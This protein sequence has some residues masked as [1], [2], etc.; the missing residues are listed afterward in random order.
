MSVDHRPFRP[1]FLPR[2]QEECAVITGRTAPPRSTLGVVLLSLSLFPPAVLGVVQTQQGNTIRSIQ[3]SPESNAAARQAIAP[4]FGMPLT[5]TV[6]RAARQRLLASLATPAGEWS[7]DTT[8]NLDING[9]WTI[10]LTPPPVAAMQP[11]REPMRPRSLMPQPPPSADRFPEAIGFSRWQQSASQVLVVR[12]DRRL[13]LKTPDGIRGFSIAIGRLGHA[14]PV[15]RRSVVSVTPNPTWYPTAAM[16]R[17]AVRRGES[18]PRRVPP[19]P[20]NPLGSHFIALGQSIGIHG[21]NAPATIGAAVSRGC[22]RMLPQ[23]ILTVAGT[24]RSGDGVWI[25]DSLESIHK[26]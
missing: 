2:L 23:D 18:L 24:L 17:D 21:T 1:L 22:I 10:T 11:R 6:R 4:L 14:T 9:R 15:G 5:P 26:L 13:W 19:G 3:F 25:V 16:H 12:A 7:V 20:S 8:A